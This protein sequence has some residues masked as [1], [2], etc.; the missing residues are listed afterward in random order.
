MP[1]ESLELQRELQQL[2]LEELLVGEEEEEE[3]LIVLI[4]LNELSLS[5]STL[6]SSC[7]V[8]VVVSDG[9]DC[10][11]STLSCA[12]NAGMINTKAGGVVV[13]GQS[14]LTVTNWQLPRFSE[15]TLRSCSFSARTCASHFNWTL[16]WLLPVFRRW[17]N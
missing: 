11:W 13:S 14:Q 2:P 7:T 1:R 4:L 10:A 16:P 12:F 8:V 17:H 6:P 3:R 5:L 15:V 9:C